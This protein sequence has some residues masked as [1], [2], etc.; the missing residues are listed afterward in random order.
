MPRKFKIGDMARVVGDDP[1]QSHGI[2]RGVKVRIVDY[3]GG[4]FP[5]EAECV[6]RRGFAEF[7]AKELEAW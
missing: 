1:E 7:R 3:T 2:P 6:H 5:Y 4:E